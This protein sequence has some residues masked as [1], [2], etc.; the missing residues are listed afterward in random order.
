VIFADSSKEFFTATPGNNTYSPAMPRHFAKVFNPFEVGS[1]V[2]GA[3]HASAAR[4]MEAAVDNEM[5]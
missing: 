2:L 5:E 3:N 4:A 1:V